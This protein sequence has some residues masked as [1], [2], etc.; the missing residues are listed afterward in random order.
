MVASTLWLSVA[1]FLEGCNYP[2]TSNNFFW[3]FFKTFCPLTLWWICDTWVPHNFR[4]FMCP[5]RQLLTSEDE[6][7][8]FI[9]IWF[10]LLKQ[11]K[12]RWWDIWI[13]C[14]GILLLFTYKMVIIHSDYILCAWWVL[15]VSRT[16]L[17]VFLFAPWECCP[18][19]CCWSPAYLAP[20][21]E[22]GPSP[23]SP[24]PGWPHFPQ[25]SGTFPLLRQI[26]CC[27]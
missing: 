1:N 23:N 24:L 8:W 16:L 13:W 21:L 22:A 11:S 27:C 12:T 3:N 6:C 19:L 2:L 14:H 4:A 25:G 7:K 18:L 26:Q 9:A 15:F 5:M 17:P 10:I 20:R